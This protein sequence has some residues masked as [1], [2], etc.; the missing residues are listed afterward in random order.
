VSGALVAGVDAGSTTAKAVVLDREARILGTSLIDSSPDLAASGRE[1]LSEALREAGALE[2]DLSFVVGTG[3]GR[4]A[5]PFATRRVTEITCHAAG[6]SSLLPG[7]RLVV[8]VGGQDSKVIRLGESGEVLDFAMN[9]KCSAG[10]GRFLNAMAAT[11]RTGLQELGPTG[12]TSQKSLNIS[13]TCTV[14][15]ESEVVSLIAQGESV[16]DIAHALHA[17]LA[18][19]LAGMVRLVG[20]GS[21][22]IFSGGGALNSDLVRC[23]EEGLELSFHIPPRP[24]ITGAL[25]AALLALRYASVAGVEAPGSPGGLDP[26]PG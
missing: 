20:A 22:A 11:L 16:P 25:G 19:R 5:L 24:Q 26:E 9:D 8:D 18:R 15:A 2:S 17:A 7:V 3:Y 21:P 14:F 23:L 13:S 12:L 6:A 1:A 10:T 4:A